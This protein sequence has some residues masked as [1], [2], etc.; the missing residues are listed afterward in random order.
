[1]SGCRRYANT[2]ICRS[3]DFRR[4]EGREP[5]DTTI[6]WRVG[7]QRY[8]WVR[9]L[10]RDRGEV[11]R[12]NDVRGHDVRGHDLRDR[13]QQHQVLVFVHDERVH[14][15][16]QVYLV[17]IRDALVLTDEHV[18]KQRQLPLVLALVQ[19]ERVR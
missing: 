1:M 3:R 12:S 16:H 9:V 10:L 19:D 4:E 7:G 11:G 13:V 2:R 15:Q 17:Y 14:Q 18:Q 8:A 5:E 6:S